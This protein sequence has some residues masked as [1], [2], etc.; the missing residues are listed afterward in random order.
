MTDDWALLI[1]IVAIIISIAS[2]VIG[3]RN[4]R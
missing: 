4:H 1:S 2:L 3:I